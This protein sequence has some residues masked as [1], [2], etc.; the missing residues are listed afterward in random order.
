MLERKRQ[1]VQEGRKGRVWRHEVLGGLE[2]ASM[3]RWHLSKALE[4]ATW[5]WADEP[6]GQMEEQVQML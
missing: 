1:R 3:G 6:S 4:G 2:K 5:I